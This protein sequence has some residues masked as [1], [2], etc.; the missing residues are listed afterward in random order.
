MSQLKSVWINCAQSSHFSCPFDWTLFAKANREFFFVLS[1]VQINTANGNNG[2]PRN[3][4]DKGLPIT[5]VRFSESNIPVNAI[6]T[7]HGQN[8][9]GMFELN[10]RDERYLPFEGAGVIGQWS[11]ELFNDLPE[12]NP[13]SENPD[14]GKPLRQFNYSTI[15]DVILH[16]NYTAKED[17]GEFKNRAI[18][19]LREYFSQNEG[20]PSLRMFNLRQD[21]PSEW[22][23][24][25]NPDPDNPEEENVF[26]LEMS[27]DL[28]PTLDRDKTLKVNTVYLLARCTGAGS[29]EVVMTPPLP[30]ESYTMT[31]EKVNQ[32]GGLHFSQKNV[33]TEGIEIV[34]TK[35]TIKW[36]LKMT[37]PD[38]GNLQQDPLTEEMEVKEMLLVLGYEW[39]EP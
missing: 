27:P 30:A 36:Q 35:P 21:F 38:G 7:S 28:F 19:H 32:Y 6:A 18:S 39:E 1:K 22:Q 34:P 15:T 4:D 11:L 16:V 8:D 2:Y 26:E 17:A 24:F 33:S 13:D 29:Y 25:L 37:R 10:F 12:N 14:F 9:S 23:R 5:D 3:T 31:L 20:T